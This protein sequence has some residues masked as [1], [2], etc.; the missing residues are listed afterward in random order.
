MFGPSDDSHIFSNFQIPHPQLSI[1]MFFVLSGLQIPLPATP[2]FCH[3]YKPARCAVLGALFRDARGPPSYAKFKTIL[4]AGPCHYA[5]K[6]EVGM[7]DVSTPACRG[8]FR[9]FFP[10]VTH[11]SV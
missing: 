2:L 4:F 1:C 5:S 6:P 11:D 10:E 8:R 7:T 9:R 3:L